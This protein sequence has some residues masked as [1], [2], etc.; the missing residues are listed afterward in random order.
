MNK[1]GQVSSRSDKSR[2]IS[3]LRLQISDQCST[4]VCSVADPKFFKSKICDRKSKI[5]IGC[6]TIRR[7]GGKYSA[8]FVTECTMIE[9]TPLNRE[10][11]VALPVHFF[12]VKKCQRLRHLRGHPPVICRFN[13]GFG[14][15][16]ADSPS[17]K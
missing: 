4:P 12:I 14:T 13:Y 8:V 6:A 10:T 17:A 11:E 3:D 9:P 7:G 2:K 16:I 15:T 1:A 5:R